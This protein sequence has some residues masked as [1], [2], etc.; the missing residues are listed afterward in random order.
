MP[1]GNLGEWVWTVS[2]RDFRLAFCHLVA[3]H[4]H[5]V[6]HLELDDKRNNNYKI[7]SGQDDDPR[8]PFWKVSLS[9][10]THALLR[11]THHLSK[12]RIFCRAEAKSSLVRVTLNNVDF[13]I[14]RVRHRLTDWLLPVVRQ[15]GFVSDRRVQG[16][17]G[18]LLE[19]ER[20]KS[21]SSISFFFRVTVFSSVQ[22]EGDPFCVCLFRT[23]F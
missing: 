2:M 5:G 22:C 8:D 21:A 9:L 11:K 12:R 6:A 3:H 20:S 15:T 4:Q 14:R 16:T 17:D 1:L 13:G 19:L 10:K 23:T 7:K 18:F